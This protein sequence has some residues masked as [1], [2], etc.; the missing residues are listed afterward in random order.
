[1]AVE[2]DL[3][4]RQRI[5]RAQE[6]IKDRICRELRSL[7]Q[8]V[9][10]QWVRPDSIHLT[11]KFL[12][13]IDERLVGDIQQAL[14]LAADAQPRFSVEVGG[15]GAFPDSRAPRVLWLGLSGHVEA[16]VR[17]AAEVDRAL[18]ALGF[19]AEAKP[20]SPHLTLARIKERSRELGKVLSGSGVL[21]HAAQLGS[22]EVRAVALMK[23]DLHPSGA[24][25]TRLVEIPLKEPQ[26]GE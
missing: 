23:S 24:V 13:D 20:Y 22:L 12:G 14:T 26:R 16:L 1:M 8:D 18:T 9:R 11:L 15:A 7:G 21:A 2:I 10:I 5:A 4:L 3:E 17:L 19:P 6:Q 25:Y